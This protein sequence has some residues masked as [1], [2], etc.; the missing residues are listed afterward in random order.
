[1]IIRRDRPLA[2]NHP[3]GL[4]SCKLSSWGAD[5]LQIIIQ[6]AGLLQMNIPHISQLCL[7]G[8]RFNL[9]KISRTIGSC[10][11][12]TITQI[13]LPRKLR[14]LF[15]AQNNFD[16]LV[17]LG[18]PCPPPLSP[19]LGAAQHKDYECAVP[20]SALTTP[21]LSHVSFKAQSGPLIIKR[22]P[23]IF[24]WS[25]PHDFWSLLEWIH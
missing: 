15:R 25:S 1:M 7:P 12:C 19:P 13:L 14:T 16:F 18:I 21:S 8:S 22:R 20:L 17:C 3:E 2:N 11:V 9:A 6:G 24:W 4:T 10:L 5:L 23:F